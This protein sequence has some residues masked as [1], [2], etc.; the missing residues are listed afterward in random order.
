MPVAANLWGQEVQAEAELERNW[1]AVQA[2]MSE[3]LADR[4]I[5]RILAEELTVPAE[6][7]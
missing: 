5:D 2:W 3:L 4:G 7:R 1:Q 6:L